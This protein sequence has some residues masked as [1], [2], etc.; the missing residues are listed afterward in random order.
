MRV[1]NNMRLVKRDRILG[2]IVTSFNSSIKL[3]GISNPK[4]R[5]VYLDLDSSASKDISIAI[6]DI[7]L[8]TRTPPQHIK[9][10]L[11]FNGFPLAREFKPFTVN[12]I[13]DEGYF[14]KVLFDV[15]PVMK[16]GRDQHTVSIY[17][18]GSESLIVNHIN[19][20]AALIA[21]GAENSYTYLSGGLILAPNTSYTLKI[22]LEVLK[23]GVGELK[24]TIDLPST[25]A[26]VHVKLNGHNILTLNGI[27]GCEEIVV[28][29]LNLKCNN[30][31]EIIHESKGQQYYPKHVKISNILLASSKML[32]PKIT[33]SGIAYSKG[34]SKLTI[35][36]KNVGHVEPDKIILLALSKGVPIARIIVN[37]IKPNEESEV[38]LPLERLSRG[39]KEL[40]LRTIWTRLGKTMYEDRKV[41]LSQLQS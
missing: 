34:I 2:E 1:L 29:N 32:K 11:W 38:E 41:N 22:P 5:K 23:G 18:E 26:R 16:L 17:Y 8:T 14:Y 30:I 19:L 10:R 31:I 9:W 27:V 25:L 12:Y 13:E 33:I 15:T 7:G 39:V 3:G 37:P 21:D 40:T 28:S 36:L 24:A 4:F 35:K 20:I 6:L